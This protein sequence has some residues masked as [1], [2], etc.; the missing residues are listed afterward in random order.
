MARQ[1]P[2]HVAVEYRKAQ[3]VGLG[4]DGARRAAANASSVVGSSPAWFSTQR[5]AVRCRLRARL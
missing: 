3:A 4:Q 1:H 5:C 2:S